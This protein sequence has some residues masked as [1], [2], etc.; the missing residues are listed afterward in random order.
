M[1]RIVAP[2]LCSRRNSSCVMVSK[3]WPSTRP[4]CA[5]C[6]KRLHDCGHSGWLATP[7]IRTQPSLNG[8]AWPLRA[9]ASTCCTAA[10]SSAR[11]CR[12]RSCHRRW[13]NEAVRCFG[14]LVAP[15]KCGVEELEQFQIFERTRHRRSPLI[16]QP[17]L[18]LDATGDVK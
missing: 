4:N 10:D 16:D 5:R 13:H 3:S 15:C 9:L 17:P 6:K 18:A 14:E 12:A 11:G 1:K 2:K 8:R 7:P